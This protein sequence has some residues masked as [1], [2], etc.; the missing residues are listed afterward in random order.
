MGNGMNAPSP[1]YSILPT[2]DVQL[3]GSLRR[4][5]C[6]L[7]DRAFL[8][9]LG[10]LP[11]DSIHVIPEAALVFTIFPKTPI[12]AGVKAYIAADGSVTISFNADPSAVTALVDAAIDVTSGR[13]F[14]LFNKD[15]HLYDRT[16]SIG[17]KSRRDAEWLDHDV[18]PELYMPGSYHGL[19]HGENS[20]TLVYNTSHHQSDKR[21]ALASIFSCPKTM[22]SSRTDS[23]DDLADDSADPNNPDDTTDELFK[24]MSHIRDLPMGEHQWEKRVAEIQPAHPRLSIDPEMV[25]VRLGKSIEVN[26][27]LD[28]SVAC[29]H[30]DNPPLGERYGQEHVHEMQD[31]ILQ[32]PAVFNPMMFCDWVAN[33]VF[34]AFPGISLPLSSFL[35]AKE[36]HGNDGMPV[37]NQ[38]ANVA[39]A[40]VEQ[41]WIDFFAY[42]NCN[43]AEIVG[44]DIQ[45][46]YQIWI[47]TEIIGS[48]D[49]R[50]RE[51]LA[52]AKK[53][54]LNKFEEK[55][56]MTV[57]VPK[58][59]FNNGFTITVNDVVNI[60]YPSITW[61]YP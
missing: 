17:K 38:Y 31:V 61:S 6:S 43:V 51:F 37:L 41:L 15:F 42:Y 28:L 48:Y 52:D 13:P 12:Q 8:A 33:Y 36:P 45:T 39:K 55:D 53:V 49:D 44:F 7:R 56:S 30:L 22:D 47:A 10:H 50:A 58:S 34:K 19:V 59:S 3:E 60:E 4:D 35:A 40:A 57:S 2:A 9:D 26:R 32:H 16:I 21:D 5:R 54:L 27:P 29:W 23:D 18:L 46:E 1:N 24:W 14:S 11:V 25:P 20:S